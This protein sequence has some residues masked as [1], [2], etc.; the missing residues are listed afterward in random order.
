MLQ[1][2]HLGLMRLSIVGT[3]AFQNKRSRYIPYKFDQID[4][5]IFKYSQDLSEYKFPKRKISEQN[6][7]PAEVSLRIY[8]F[9]HF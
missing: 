6:I 9:L 7:A 1:L 8:N 2:C 5:F 3:A 4:D